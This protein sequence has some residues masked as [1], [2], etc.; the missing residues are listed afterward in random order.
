MPERLPY[1]LLRARSE[2]AQRRSQRAAARQKE[3]M[4]KVVQALDDENH[5]QQPLM[6]AWLT[7]L[8]SCMLLGL[9]YLAWQTPG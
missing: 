4:R 9:L 3:V 6:P 7:V 1:Q 2:A 8:L 5:A